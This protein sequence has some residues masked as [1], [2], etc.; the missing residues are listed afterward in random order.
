MLTIREASY[1]GNV[2]SVFLLAPGSESI[3]ETLK[4]VRETMRQRFRCGESPREGHSPMLGKIAFVKA[5]AG[6]LH[7]AAI[8]GLTHELGGLFDVI[9]IQSGLQEYV[10]AAV[11]EASPC[12][13]TL[14]Q[15]IATSDVKEHVDPWSKI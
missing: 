15:T 4:Q 1:K 5:G 11:N 6:P 14:G 3:G 10:I 2:A 9:G 7:P 13:C 12:G 8:A